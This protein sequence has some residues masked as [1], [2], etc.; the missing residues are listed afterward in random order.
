MNTRTVL[1]ITLVAGIYRCDSKTKNTFWSK[2]D[3]SEKSKTSSLLNLKTADSETFPKEKK[4]KPKHKLANSWNFAVSPISTLIKDAPGTFWSKRSIEEKNKTNV[5]LKVETLDSE[6]FPMEKKDKPIQFH[7]PKFSF[8]VKNAS[9]KQKEIPAFIK[10]FL[11]VAIEKFLAN[12]SN[13]KKPFWWKKEVGKTN[14]AVQFKDN[15]SNNLCDKQVKEKNNSLER[16][17]CLLMK[18]VFKQNS[19]ANSS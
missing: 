19:L 18:Q 13:G 8:L 12:K 17:A 5:L 16:K 1:L 6:T 4:D 2:R 11:F 10:N 7:L 14:E 3:I 15:R 9:G